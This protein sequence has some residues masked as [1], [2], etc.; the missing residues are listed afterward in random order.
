MSIWEASLLT[1]GAFDTVQAFARLMNNIR[2]PGRLN[3]GANYHLFKDGIRP[4]C[5]SL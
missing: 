2:E 1:V 5:P 3:K 4:V